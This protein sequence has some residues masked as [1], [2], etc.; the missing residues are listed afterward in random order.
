MRT[1]TKKLESLDEKQ[2]QAI[3]RRVFL[4]DEGRIV[5]EDLKNRC[6]GYCPTIMTG[7]MV[8]PLRAMFNEGSRSVVLHIETLLEENEP[9]LEGEED[10]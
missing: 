10:V 7:G 8:D 9:K 2:I 5:L 4:T 1:L 3:Y 6:Y